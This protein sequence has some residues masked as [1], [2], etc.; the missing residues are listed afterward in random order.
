MDFKDT[1]ENLKAQSDNP[2]V[3]ECLESMINEDVLFN[4]GFTQD[5]QKLSSLYSLRLNMAKD[6]NRD[7]FKKDELKNWEIAVN[8]LNKSSCEELRLNW[9]HSEQKTF[10]LYWDASTDK[11]EALFYLYS[12]SSMTEQELNN[13]KII[14]QGYSVSSVKYAKGTRVKDWKKAP[15]RVGGREP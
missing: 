5:K 7:K 14:E 10:M 9:V 1:I 12:K 11:L 6:L 15:N 13:D 3:A 4:G 8:S 2:L